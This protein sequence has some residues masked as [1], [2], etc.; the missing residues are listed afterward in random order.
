MRFKWWPNN[1]LTFHKGVN[2]K[3]RNLMEAGFNRYRKFMKVNICGE[4]HAAL[5][6]MSVK[7]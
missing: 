1:H 4:W 7:T 5:S 6:S 3:R 2:L